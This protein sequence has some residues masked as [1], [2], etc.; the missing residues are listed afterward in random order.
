M[1]SDN[2]VFLRGR[3]GA[4]PESRR[5]P[6]GVLVVRLRLAT[7]ARWSSDAGAVSERTDW[8]NVD[9][10]GKSAEFCLRYLQKGAPVLV[11]GAIRNDRVDREGVSRVFSTVRAW[12]VVSL[13]NGGQRLADSEANGGGGAP[14]PPQGRALPF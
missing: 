2:C 10:W 13:A 7:H 14:V 1:K 9:V 8:H 6:S 11:M 4:D 3:L 5:L 12:E